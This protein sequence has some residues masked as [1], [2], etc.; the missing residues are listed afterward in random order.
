[1][2]DEQRAGE[3]TPQVEDF[4]KYEQKQLNLQAQPVDVKTCFLRTKGAGMKQ[5]SI[6]I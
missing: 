4:V 5:Y 2:I 3:I 6:A 1:L